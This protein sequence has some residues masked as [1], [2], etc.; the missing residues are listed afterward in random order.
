MVIASSVMVAAAAWKMTED[1]DLLS[2][3]RPLVLVVSCIAVILLYGA[4]TVRWTRALFRVG[5]M[6]EIDAAGIVDRRLGPD[7]IPWSIVRSI[8]LV[9]CGRR[10]ALALAVDPPAGS[11]SRVP[12][13]RP[14]IAGRQD[15]R[16]L[17]TIRIRLT[18][19]DRSPN[20]IL[21]AIENA[22]IAR[23]RTVG[24]AQAA[25]E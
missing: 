18:G 20:S 10:P 22:V 14:Y 2:T 25:A 8:R 24:I 16:G 12:G 9:G 15:A 4:F 3:E 7:L 21:K 6:L 13:M 1:P 19:L 17:W 5:P 23:N 11:L